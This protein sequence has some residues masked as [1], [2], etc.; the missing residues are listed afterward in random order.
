MRRL[1][2]VCVMHPSRDLSRMPPAITMRHA[3]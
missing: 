2:A 3:P 1:S